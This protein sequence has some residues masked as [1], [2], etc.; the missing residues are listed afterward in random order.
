MPTA[1]TPIACELRSEPLQQRL[2]WIRRVT[3]ESLTTHR[4]EGN[5]LHLTYQRQAG[6]EVEKI[7]A[8]EQRCCAFLRFSMRDVRDGVE[9]QI[10][11]PEGVGAD[12]LW[13]FDQFLPRVRQV[14]APKL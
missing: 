9:L 2:T 5:A 3:N 14:A 4:L 10:Q 11:A 8:E 1:D 12:A 7:G 6:P 13:L